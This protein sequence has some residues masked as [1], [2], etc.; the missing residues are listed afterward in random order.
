MLT[1]PPESTFILLYTAGKSHYHSSPVLTSSNNDPNSLLYAKDPIG[2]SVM[3]DSIS[4]K[5]V[6]AG[7]RPLGFQ[8]FS[9]NCICLNLTAYVQGTMNIHYQS[10]ILPLE[11]LSLNHSTRS[12]STM[13]CCP[14]LLL[15][16]FL[17]SNFHKRKQMC[18][19]RV[20]GQETR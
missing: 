10:M 13:A 4:V 16:C 6:G 18:S 2:F 5:V 11:G 1:A 3:C 17:Q 14:S 15:F 8:T 19:S 9:A 20:S 12:N 7:S